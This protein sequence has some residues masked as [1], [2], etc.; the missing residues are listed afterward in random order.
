MVLNRQ[1]SAERAS[2]GKALQT[3]VVAMVIRSWGGG[4]L[5]GDAQALAEV[6]QAMLSQRRVFFEPV[7]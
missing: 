3:A 7:L 5:P 4:D 2:S 1:I 6:A